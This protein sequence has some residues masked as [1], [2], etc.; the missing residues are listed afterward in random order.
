MKLYCDTISI[1]SNASID[2]ID[3][4][5]RVSEAVKKSGVK[6]GMA[7]VTTPHTTAGICI[8]EPCPNL[9]EDVTK[10]LSKMTEGF[11][12]KHDIETIDGRPNGKSHLVAH[13]LPRSES[14]PV[15]EGK[16]LLGTWQA[17]FFMELDGPRERRRVDVRIIG[18]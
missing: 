4:T 7:F 16:A 6:S 12:S 18:E 3:V 8:N 5:K 13:L 2:V 10:F 9:R 1:D 11:I 17:V 14:I 15:E